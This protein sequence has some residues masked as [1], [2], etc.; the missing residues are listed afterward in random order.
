MTTEPAYLVF[1]DN[2][3]SGIGIGI[4]I[5]IAIGGFQKTFE[6]A[7]EEKIHLVLL[8]VVFVPQFEFFMITGI[9]VHDLL[10]CMLH[11][12]GYVVV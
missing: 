9:G 2:A 5:G 6:V 3:S 7:H 12:V 1:V 11:T 8:M 10:R 4:G